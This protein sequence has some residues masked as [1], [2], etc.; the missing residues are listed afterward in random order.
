MHVPPWRKSSLMWERGRAQP[1]RT[2]K[3]KDEPQLN[4][5]AFGPLQW[6]LLESIGESGLD[7][8]EGEK[9]PE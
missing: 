3:W 1:G 7:S 2:D 4:S 8:V 9:N 5:P 6:K